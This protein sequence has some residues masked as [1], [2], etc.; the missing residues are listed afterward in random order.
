MSNDKDISYSRPEKGSMTLKEGL[1]DC[2]W[3]TE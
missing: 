3:V 1:W 2:R